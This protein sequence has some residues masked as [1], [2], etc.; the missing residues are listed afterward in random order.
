MA[1]DVQI[2]SSEEENNI[3]VQVDIPPEVFEAVKS[4]AS[5][6]D[7]GKTLIGEL[8]ELFKGKDHV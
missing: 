2:N 8:R 7:A 6:F 3:R 4:L 1:L 5:A